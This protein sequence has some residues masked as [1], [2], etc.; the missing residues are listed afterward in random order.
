[1]NA[2][3]WAWVAATIAAIAVAVWLERRRAV[4]YRKVL[5]LELEPVEDQ[6]RRAAQAIRELPP[7]GPNPEPYLARWKPPG[8]SE[9]A[10]AVRINAV[11]LGPSAAVDLL[12][13]LVDELGDVGG[14]EIQLP[15]GIPGLWRFNHCRRLAD[16]LVP[17]LRTL[18][19]DYPESADLYALKHEV[20]RS[21]RL[22]EHLPRAIF[23]D[24]AGVWHPTRAAAVAANERIA[25][26]AANRIHEAL[27][28]GAGD[29]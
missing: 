20:E 1:M 29:A 28:E 12:V 3:T 5:P 26:K 18:I 16:G 2:A 17:L 23:E 21:A 27:E 7:E 14:W 4:R 9:F 22:L 19:A 8:S 10:S 6:L 11:E 13:H 24:A 15:A 25:A